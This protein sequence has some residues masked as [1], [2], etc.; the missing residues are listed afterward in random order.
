MASQTATYGFQ[1]GEGEADVYTGGAASRSLKVAFKRA[2]YEL[3]VA[4]KA[5]IS[6]TDDNSKFQAFSA[7]NI[8]NRLTTRGI[9]VQ[10]LPLGCRNRQQQL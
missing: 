6:T 4:I 5:R 8:V 7:K 9:Q 1:R 3:N 2:L 10:D